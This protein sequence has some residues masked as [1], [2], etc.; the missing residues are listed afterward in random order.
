MA[1]LL[2]GGT[3]A[4][5]P[6]RRFQLPPLW[7]LDAPTP[8]K[9]LQSGYFFAVRNPDLSPEWLESITPAPVVNWCWPHGAVGTWLP[10]TAE[11]QQPL[12]PPRPHGHPPKED[13]VDAVRPPRN[14]HSIK[15][16][17]KNV[18]NRG[19]MKF[20]SCRHQP[21]ASNM[22]STVG[23]SVMQLQVSARLI[24]YQKKV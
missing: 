17:K 13:T 21:Y 11:S 20:R 2:P 10:Q 9:E 22:H 15:K 19:L 6:A 18:I 24:S 4:M 16:K 14:L 23:A 5:A 1:S 3:G 7:G 12:A 8:K